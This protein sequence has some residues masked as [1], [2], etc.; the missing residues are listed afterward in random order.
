MEKIEFKDLNSKIEMDQNILIIF[1]A[2]WCGQCK[3]AKL[4]IK[5]IQGDYPNLIFVE[6][7]VDDNNLW[8]NEQLNIKSVPTFLGY[9]NKEQIFNVSGYQ[10]EENLKE[11]L[12]KFN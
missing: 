12:Q 4:L 11:L 1:G 6:I 9:K 7:D 5:K 3:M 2:E 8:E 10:T